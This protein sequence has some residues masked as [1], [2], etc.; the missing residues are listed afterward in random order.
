MFTMASINIGILCNTLGIRAYSIERQCLQW[1]RIKIVSLFTLV[2]CC[3]VMKK[4]N[5]FD[6]Y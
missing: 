2:K 6:R 3:C 5:L 1:L 4:G